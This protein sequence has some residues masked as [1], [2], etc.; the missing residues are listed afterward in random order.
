MGTNNEDFCGAKLIYAPIRSVSNQ[1]LAE[2][3]DLAAQLKSE[4]PDFMM[5]FDLVGQEDMGRP[6]IDFADQLIEFSKTPPDIP[7]FFHAGET[8]WQGVSTDIN[9]VDAILL[10]T[11]RIGH[12]YAIVKHPEAKVLAREKDIPLEICP[13][14]NQVLGLVNDVRNH[15]G[16]VLIQEGFPLVISSDDPGA[17]GTKALSYDF[18]EAF[19]AMAS[20]DMDLHLLKKLVENSVKYAKFSNTEE[21]NRCEQIVTD[22]WKNFFLRKSAD[23]DFLNRKSQK[24]SLQDEIEIFTNEIVI[25]Y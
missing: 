1:R 4:Y 22:Q 20:R 9:I 10:N 23:R 5:G 6:L 11:T 12:G 15:P 8:N 19:M 16:S 17:W 18:Y 21:K 13:V 25:E 3:F 7:F 2:Y 14:S 24:I